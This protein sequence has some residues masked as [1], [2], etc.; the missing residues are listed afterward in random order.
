MDHYTDRRGICKPIFDRSL[1]FHFLVENSMKSTASRGIICPSG[2]VGWDI[3]QCQT[4]IFNTVIES[5]FRVQDGL[6]RIFQ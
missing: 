4:E 5:S 2:A 1:V 6:G 3:S